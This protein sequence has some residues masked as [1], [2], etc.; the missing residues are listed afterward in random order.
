MGTGWPP[1][2]RAAR[3]PGW[4]AH[5]NVLIAAEPDVRGIARDIATRLL[6]DGEIRCQREIVVRSDSGSAT[7][8]YA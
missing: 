2:A 8:P 3:C 1:R 7:V 4:L 6:L 5:R